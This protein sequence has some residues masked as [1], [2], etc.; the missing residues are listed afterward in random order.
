[1][2]KVRCAQAFPEGQ[3]LLPLL[4]GEDF[5]DFLEYA[6]LPS[7]TWPISRREL[8]FCSVTRV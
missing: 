8:V 3:I 5:L 6:K 7:L 4:L 1:V 2:S